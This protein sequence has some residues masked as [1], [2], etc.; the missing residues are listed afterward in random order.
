MA[1]PVDGGAGSSRTSTP[2]VSVRLKRSVVQPTDDLVLW[3]I[4]RGGTNALS[5]NYY[6][7]FM[8]A[9]MCGKAPPD[10]DLSQGG[11]DE[12]RSQIKGHNAMP[13]P[14][15]E[16]YRMLKAGTEVFMMAYCGVEPSTDLS[17]RLKGLVFKS[18][19][20]EAKNQFAAEEKVRASYAD[21]ADPKNYRTIYDDYLETVNDIESGTGTS[22]A[23][24]PKTLPY[25][26]LIRRKLGDL[27]LKS[28]IEDDEPNID[29]CYGVLV[30]KLQKPC[31]LELIWSYW[32]EEAMLVQTLN[33]I[34]LR[35]QNRR[36]PTGRDPLAHF[37]ID[38]LRPLSNILWGYIQDE[39]H[40]LT[41]Q[42]RAYEYLHH[43]GITLQGKA[44]PALEAA[45]T[46]TKFLEAFH[47][48]LNLTSKFY[49]QDDDT[50]VIA[51]GFPVLNALK[52]VHLILSEGAHNQYGDLPW[53]A[54]QEMLMQ[55]W[56]LAR[57]EFREFLP[58]R[59]MVAYPEPW[60]DRVDAM[61]K[62]QSWDNTSV[63]HYRDLGVFGEQV[64]LSVRFGNWS[65]V[66]LPEQAANWARYWR[67]EIQSYIH[68]YRTVTGVDLSADRVQADKVDY[69]MPS[70]HLVKRLAQQQ[71][72]PVRN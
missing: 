7:Q 61:K 17:K 13:F 39:Q 34:S 45:E 56:I 37:E 3:A 63:L 55:E 28:S 23:V 1:Q 22:T 42:R 62:I 67:P 11:V 35:F 2:D 54:R 16:S 69:Q 24:R 21:A 70:V 29:A 5:F 65:E 41:V 20:A 33:A 43:Y 25:L 72:Q 31:L 52:E 32:H 10:K 9:V 26:A 40:R 51:D 49:K 27:P 4:I 44:V 12:L 50:T 58:T 36:L 64:L 53:T 46:R 38:P 14:D 48:L 68:A 66:F 15:I 8:D 18:D 60:M 57:P 30:R 47:S 6:K 71:H 19:P 59:I